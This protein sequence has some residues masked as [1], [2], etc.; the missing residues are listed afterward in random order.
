MK[1]KD[2]RLLYPSMQQAYFCR[3]SR[4]RAKN[5]RCRIPIHPGTHGNVFSTV[6]RIIRKRVPVSH[7]LR[8][9]TNRRSSRR[10]S[11]MVVH[12]LIAILIL[13]L[14]L[15]ME[16]HRILPKCLLHRM[17]NVCHQTTFQLFTRFR[18]FP[19]RLRL[20]HNHRTKQP[21][22]IRSILSAPGITKI[23]KEKNTLFLCIP[24]I[25]HLMPRG[26]I[27][28]ISD[29]CTI[30]REHIIRHPLHMH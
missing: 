2:M 16:K 17:I 9:I 13:H 1:M 29:I 22:C 28:I 12:R 5:R 24:F 20:L 7:W 11:C 19:D 23:T 14:Q 6:R 26:R 25:R 21:M 15:I 4:I 3:I 10:K 27:R 18:I 8:T 30:R